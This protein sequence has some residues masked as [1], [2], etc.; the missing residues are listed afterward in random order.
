MS[1][2]SAIPAQTSK[3]STNLGFAPTHVT[4]AL[5]TSGSEQSVLPSSVRRCRA[6]IIPRGAWRIWSGKISAAN[7]GSV[8]YPNRSRRCQTFPVPVCRRLRCP[9]QAHRLPFQFP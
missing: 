5:R 8:C 6:D 7:L 3:P 1:E 9:S 2:G 4:G